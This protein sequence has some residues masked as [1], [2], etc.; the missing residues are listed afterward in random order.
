MKAAA[1]DERDL[2]AARRRLDERVA[3]RVGQ[4]AAAVEQRA[5]D[6]NGQQADH[7][8][9]QGRWGRWGGRWHVGR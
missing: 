2:D 4:T 1:G 8:G 6:V 7:Q 5:I 9:R 3:V